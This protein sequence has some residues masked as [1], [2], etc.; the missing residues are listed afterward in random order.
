M[1]SLKFENNITKG[2]LF[3]T[4]Q[5]GRNHK[6][7]LLPSLYIGHVKS[8]EVCLLDLGAAVHPQFCYAVM[9]LAAVWE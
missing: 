8:A 2:G 5:Q 7:L 6:R 3:S 1:P 9:V 4:K